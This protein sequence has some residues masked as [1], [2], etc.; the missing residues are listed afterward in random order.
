[1]KNIVGV[2][3]GCN[4]YKIIDMGVM[5]SCQAIIDECIRNN[6]DIVGLSGFITPSFEEMVFYAK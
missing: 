2:V 4:N 5:K 6:A 1:M 3:L